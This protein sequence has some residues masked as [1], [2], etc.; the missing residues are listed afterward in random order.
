ML[1]RTCTPIPSNILHIPSNIL[2]AHTQ[3]CLVDVAATFANTTG[4]CT[5]VSYRYPQTKHAF[6]SRETHRKA[7]NHNKHTS[8]CGTSVCGTMPVDAMPSP[9]LGKQGPTRKL[10]CVNSSHMH[11]QAPPPRAEV[12]PGQDCTHIHTQSNIDTHM[13]NT[14]ID[15]SL[16]F[17]HP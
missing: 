6:S 13:I 1:L 4:S 16:P 14:R 7:F 10:R 2:H 8:K 5:H 17:K 15:T 12:P 3:T 9:R 11:V